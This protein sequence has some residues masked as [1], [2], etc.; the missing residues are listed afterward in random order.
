MK[1]Y[2]DINNVRSE[3]Q[4]IIYKKIQDEKIDPFSP[5]HFEKNHPHPI[6]FQNNSWFVTK[7]AFP[8]ENS[9]LHLLLVHKEFITSIEEIS[10][11]GW[12]D[13][14]ETIIYC[15]Q[16]FNL[17]SGSFFMRFGNTIK[18]GSS[19]THLHAHIIVSNGEPNKRK[20]MYVKIS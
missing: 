3:E 18:T 11:D 19:V 14:Q 15:V 20:T 4:K 6:I 2:V 12:E 8:Y 16:K 5:E 17:K 1:K 7:N 10:K 13:L 9:S